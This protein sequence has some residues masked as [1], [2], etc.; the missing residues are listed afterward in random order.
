MNRHLL[1]ARI[2]FIYP[3]FLSIGLIYFKHGLLF[4][5]DIIENVLTIFVVVATCNIFGRNR[6]SLIIELIVLVGF[7]LFMFIEI[8]H[9]YLYKDFF[10]ASAIFILIETSPAESG[11]FLTNYL[12]IKL[13]FAGCSIVAVMIFS[14]IQLVENFYKNEFFLFDFKIEL[15]WVKWQLPFYLFYLLGFCGFVFFINAAPHHR[16][17]IVAHTLVDGYQK[18]L[19]HNAAYQSLGKEKRGGQFSKVKHHHTTEAETYI[20]VIGESTTRNHMNLYGYSRNTTPRLNE[21]KEELLIFT[22]VISPHTNTIPTL[23]KVLTLANYEAPERKF[24]GSIIQLFNKANFKTYWVS[25]Q[26]PIGLH[27]TFVTGISNSCDQQFFLSSYN[28]VPYDEVILAPLVTVLNDTAA[29]KIIFI[30]LMGT[31]IAYEN[32]YPDSFNKFKSI[33]ATTFKHTLAYHRINAYDN[34][35]LYN[36]YVVREIIEQVRKTEKKSTLVYFLDHGEEVYETLDFAGHGGGILSRSMYEIPF[37]LWRT[38]VEEQK[39]TN[40]VVDTNRKWMIDDLLFTMADLANIEFEESKI[41]RS[42]FS[43]AFKERKRV[44]LKNT[45]YEK[46]FGIEK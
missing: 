34:A 33:P 22:D 1:K 25:T 26:Q 43:K 3:I 4:K 12:D 16:R 19:E 13:V 27:E 5:G 38:Q 21:I 2:G 23:S 44:I 24:D 36:D 14:I 37:M 41:E 18:Y 29:K 17:Y 39:D 20:V 7:N 8:T 45:T 15:P 32:R 9:L 46:Q 40:L 6:F 42:L 30:H 31:H 11:E 28:E 35:V 10:S